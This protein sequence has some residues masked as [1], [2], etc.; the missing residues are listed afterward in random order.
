MHHLNSYFILE[1]VA[2]NKNYG[3]ISATTL[4]LDISGFTRITEALMEHGQHGAEVLANIVREIF[5]PLVTCI[6]SYGGDI[7]HFAGDAFQTIFPIDNETDAKI[8]CQRTLAAAHFIQAQ[9]E[10]KATFQ[11]EYGVFEFTAK[12]GLSVGE[13]EWGIISGPK[14]DVYYFRGDAIDECAM[15]ENLGSGGNIIAHERF[16]RLVDLGETAVSVPQNNTYHYLNSPPKQQPSPHITA[17]PSTSP[18]HQRFTPASMLNTKIRGEFRY[19]CNLFLNVDQVTSHQDI[20]TFMD[21]FFTAINPYEGYIN[22]L[23]FGDKGC[24][25]LIFWGAPTTHENDLSRALNFALDLQATTPLPIRMGITYG[26]AHAG[27]IGSQLREEYTCYGHRVNMAARL[28]NKAD[29]NTIWLGDRAFRHAQDEFN[30]TYLEEIPLKGVSHIQPVYQLEGQQTNKEPIQYTTSMIGREPEL[31]QIQNSLSPIFN[32]QFAGIITIYGEAGIGKSRLIYELRQNLI[33]QAELDPT[34]TVSWLYCPVDEILRQPLNPFR[35]WMRNYFQQSRTQTEAENKQ[36]FQQILNELAKQ[37]NDETVIHELHR[38]VSI[39]GA[40]IDLHW[41]DSLYEQLEPRLRSEN[42]QLALINLIKAQTL[43]HPVILEIE[44]G[45]W[46]DNESKELIGALTR[47]LSRHS[48]TILLTNR[49]QDDGTIFALP[50]DDAVPR[51]EIHLTYL[52]VIG[53][54]NLA[55]QTLAGKITQ[56][57]LRFLMEKTNGNPFFAEQLLLDLKERESIIANKAEPPIFDFR[58]GFTLEDVPANLRAVLISRL[59]RLID[60]TRQI[61]Q[62]AAVLGQEFDIGVL[63]A[64][65]VEFDDLTEFIYQGENEQIWSAI[66]KILYAFKHALMRDAAYGM[67]LQSHLQHL[68]A[69][70]ALAY[71]SLYEDNLSEHY[72]NLAYHYEQA[73]IANKAIKYLKLAGDAAKSSYQNEVALDF[74]N[75]LLSLQLNNQTQMEVTLSIAEIQNIQGKWD[76]AIAQLKIGLRLAEKSQHP[77]SKIKFRTMLGDVLRNKG[78]YAEAFIYLDEAEILASSI[79]NLQLQANILTIKS[80]GNVYRKQF[81]RALIEIEKAYTYFETLNNKRGMA[82]ASALIGANY[83]VTNNYRNALPYL[84]D[85]IKVFKELNNRAELSRPIHNVGLVYYFLGEYDKSEQYLSQAIKICTEIGNQLTLF[86]SQFRLAQLYHANNELDRAITYFEKALNT[87]ERLGSVGIPSAPKP[88]LAW[89]YLNKSIYDKAIK[90]SF[91]HIAESEKNGRDVEFGLGHFV[92]GRLLSII[93]SPQEKQTLLQKY[94]PSSSTI[95]N[96]DATPQAYFSYA[97]NLSKSNNYL[98]TMIPSLSCFGEFLLLNER[99]D[100]GLLHIKEA[101]ETAL[102]HEMMGE[103]KNIQIICQKLG[104]D[105]DNL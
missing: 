67:Q 7:T 48:F 56:P 12:V 9:M 43:L 45:H 42:R 2:Q 91:E 57:V 5:D 80:R 22:R 83:G 104:I 19:T 84:L 103:L 64:M 58:T 11:T 54:Q 23:A 86:A 14:Q 99:S 74:Y 63:K 105:F 72:A 29:W 81:S 79:N 31:A 101:K 61:V 33:Q 6:Y 30:I 69:F 8:V 34:K 51:Q 49:Y 28:M 66:S 47:N 90:F 97:I 65:A 16:E 39:L 89:T 88:Y 1:Q 26:I 25:L 96:I 100:K 21:A 27:Y 37:L 70:A 10:S 59:D 55:E 32:G 40:I 98:E 4:F 60:E 24:H 53:I 92:I 87:K 71:E 102:Q 85:S 73:E 13:L 76:E 41:A 17:T 15:A 82:E 93:D 95:P 44:D 62:M 94:Q 35:Y 52:S 36:I 20:V 78:N 77:I 38:T 18:H 75:R 46:L 50:I 3:R 68:H